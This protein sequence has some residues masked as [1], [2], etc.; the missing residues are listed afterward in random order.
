MIPD[1]FTCLLNR[2]KCKLTIGV[3]D[4][5]D[6]RSLKEYA[7]KW[8]AGPSIT[9]MPYG[10]ELAGVPPSPLTTKEPKNKKN[11]FKYYY[12]NEV[13][14]GSDVYGTSGE[15]IERE[16]FQLG[17][18]ESFCLRLDGDD[19]VVRA[20]GVL[21]SNG[22]PEIACRLEE[23]G[24]YWCY[25]YEYEREQAVSMLVYATNSV[26]GT[27]IYIE[28]NGEKLIGLYFYNGSSKVYVYESK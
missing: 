5:E 27:R 18:S 10:L 22:R 14:I 16:V 24:E 20:S 28:K 25:E 26:P 19:E 17:E 11:C 15:K 9:I 13:L 4:L 6:F 2:V 8:S 3:D 21:Y 12:D 7:V 1:K 23:D